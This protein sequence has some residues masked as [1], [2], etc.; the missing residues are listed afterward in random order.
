MGSLTRS[1]SLPLARLVGGRGGGQL[2]F[3]LIYLFAILGDILATVSVQSH[4]LNWPRSWGSLAPFP[5]GGCSSHSALV[6]FPVGIYAGIAVF[7]ALALCSYLGQ[8]YFN[9]T[10]TNA[11]LRPLSGAD[12]EKYWVGSAQLGC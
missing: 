9:S 11:G 4:R 2:S 5:G 10:G 3:S 8:A 12:T 6:S 1:K 7:S